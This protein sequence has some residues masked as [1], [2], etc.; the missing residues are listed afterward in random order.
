M[1]KIVFG[2]CLPKY[3]Q[4]QQLGVESE[5]ESESEAIQDKTDSKPQEVETDEIFEDVEVAIQPITIH[6]KKYLIDNDDDLYDI[7]TEIKI[8]TY[9]HVSDEI[10]FDEA[11]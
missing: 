7:D 2:I 5:S 8:G 11:N 6:S 3:K 10:I 4:Q 1:V 9:D